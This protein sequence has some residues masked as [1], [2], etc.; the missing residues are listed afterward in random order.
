MRNIF[1]T[2]SSGYLGTRLIEELGEREDVGTIV[3]SDIAAPRTDTDRC[4]FLKMDIRDPGMDRVLSQHRID[5]VI[6][7]AFVVKPIHDLAR[8]H[9]IDT[10]GTRNVLQ[11]SYDA[12]VRHIV[13]ISS[14]LAYGAHPDNP[15]E[16]KENDPLRGNRSY[17]YGYNKARVDEMIQKFAADHPEITVTILRPCTVFGPTVDNY[18]SRMLFQPLTAGILGSNPPVQFVH[19]EDFVRACLIAVE[20]RIP[21]TFNI[22]GKGAL[23]TKEVASILGTR[24]IP[25]P[26]LLLYPLVEMLWRLHVP[27]IEVNRG[28]L[29]YA[30]YGFVAGGEKA[31]AELG[32]V[33]VF[34]SRQVLEDTVRKRRHADR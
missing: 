1:I 29:D 18:V 22:V 23:T 13:A 11:K 2:G 3:G 10:N 28:Y 24:I 4:N 21:G 16:L 5:T 17:A 12:G 30:R 27:G 26:A 20:K 9:D 15:P 32:F 8:M 6:H 19:E 34:S 14:T 31:E 25:L 7:L 33:P